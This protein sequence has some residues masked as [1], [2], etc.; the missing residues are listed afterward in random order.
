MV[1]QLIWNDIISLNLIENQKSQWYQ[2]HA[3]GFNWWTSSI[4][5]GAIDLECHYLF[6]FN[7]ESNETITCKLMQLNNFL[8]R[9]IKWSRMTFSLLIQLW[10]KG[11]NSNNYME[12]DAIDILPQLE[13]QRI[14]N[15]V[16][17]LNSIENK[18][19]QQYHLHAKGLN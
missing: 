14:C 15:D 17:P 4:L 6:P 9:R 1:E 3:I 16:I 11:D 13:E 12:W 7:W 18:R 19:Q 2:L 8:S 5:G 10:I